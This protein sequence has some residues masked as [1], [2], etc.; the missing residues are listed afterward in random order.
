MTKHIKS[1]TL[2]QQRTGLP[3]RGCLALRR[4]G[5]WALG[6]SLVL[7]AAACGS[8]D[9]AGTASSEPVAVTTDVATTSDLPVATAGGQ[10]SSVPDEPS[11]TEAPAGVDDGA[12]DAIVEAAQAEGSVMFYTV[13]VPALVE[14]VGQAFEDEYGIEFEYVRNTGPDFIAAVETELDTGQGI[15]DVIGTP[16]LAWLARMDEADN[17]ESLADLPN[18][19]GPDFLPDWLRG[20]SSYILESVYANGWGYN[21]DQ[22]PGGPTSCD[23]LLAPELDGLIGVIDPTYPEAVDQL[24]MYEDQCGEGFIEKLGEMN[25]GSMQDRFQWWNRWLRGRRSST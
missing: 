5:R 13:G 8:D 17:W 25:R 18:V 11:E 3:G 2:D 7:A 12:W 21:S 10:A 4:P 16:D 24:V 9:Q 1:P 20:N 19:S 23:D 14:P 6:A 15:G 22:Y